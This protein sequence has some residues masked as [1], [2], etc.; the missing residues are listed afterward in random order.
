MRILNSIKIK[1]FQNINLYFELINEILKTSVT[2]LFSALLCKQTFVAIISNEILLDHH[3][4]I[5]E[6][7]KMFVAHV[8]FTM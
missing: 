5:K 7:G 3:T 8:M 2:T 6:R 1:S 4:L